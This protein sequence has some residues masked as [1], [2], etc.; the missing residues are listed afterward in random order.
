[1]VCFGRQGV[2]PFAGWELGAGREPGGSWE[3]EEEVGG[4]R[5]VRLEQD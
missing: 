1:M 3:E 2:G 5:L 4:G